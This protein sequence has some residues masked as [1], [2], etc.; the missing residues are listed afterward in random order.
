[1]KFLRRYRYPAAISKRRPESHQES[2][3]SLRGADILKDFR[4][5]ST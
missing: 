1:M 5:L 2:A 3:L 4:V